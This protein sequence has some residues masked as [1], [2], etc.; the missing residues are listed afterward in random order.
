MTRAE[1]IDLA[2]GLTERKATGVLPLPLLY[3]HAL[4]E[5]CGE[6]RFWWRKRTFY[7]NTVAGTA[8][9]DL[10]SVALT[11]AQ[12]ELIAEEITR[13]VWVS[14]SDLF[15]LP[16]TFD[17]LTTIED[18]EATATGQPSAYT[19]DLTDYKTLRICPTPDAA[20]KI[21]MV[22]WMMP[23]PGTDSAIDAVP[24]VPPQFHRGIVH[25][26][27]K[28]IWRTVYG[29][30]DPKTVTAQQAYD[31]VVQLAQMRP[32]FTTNYTQQFISSEDS[33]QST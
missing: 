1:I 11:P 18:V 7:F 27:E 30:E 4:Q 19:F 32:R 8:T 12:T 29:V 2:N 3:Q 9:Y 23:N 14:S 22:A 10:S 28:Y 15:E 33:I 6:N 21:R 24:L 31:K 25:A 20:Y 13:V 5:F 16:P 17:D 26:M